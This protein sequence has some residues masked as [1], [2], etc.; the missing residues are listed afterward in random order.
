MIRVIAVALAAASALASV[1]PPTPQPARTSG[2]RAA[3]ARAGRVNAG[4]GIAAPAAGAG[5][6]ELIDYNPLP[7]AGAA[8]VASDNMARFTVL[9]P[10]LIRMEY[11]RAAGQF[12]DRA[13]LAMMNRN[14]PLPPFTHAEVRAQRRRGLRC[15]APAARAPDFHRSQQ[16]QRSHSP[17]PRTRPIIA[18]NF[19]APSRARA[20]RLAA[21]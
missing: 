7:T 12:E 15:C 18:P 16:R 4:T 3:A 10:R 14:T 20:R 8:I 2:P 17:S 13:T 9:T 11:A 19:N 1:A 5:R 21:C 6:A